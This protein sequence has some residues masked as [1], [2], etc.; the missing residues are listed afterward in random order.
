MAL[1]EIK[2]EP[3][4]I[5]LANDKV[6]QAEQV[7]SQKIFELGQAY[8][9]DNKNADDS[10]KYFEYIDRIK[11]AEEN[12]K[13]FFKAKL[14][15]EGQALCDNCGKTVVLGS[16][17]CNFCGAKM[18]QEPVEVQPVSNVCKNCG[19]TLDEGALFCGSC[20]TKVE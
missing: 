16:V 17:F 3:T 20:G 5:D 19:K 6:K 18:P 8:F 7:V 2:K 9:N 1:F 15:L 14:K 12:R 10:D 11:K 13:E 4:E